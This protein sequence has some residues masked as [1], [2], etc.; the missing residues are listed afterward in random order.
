MDLRKILLLFTLAV[1]ATAQAAIV[2]EVEAVETVTSNIS[3]PTSTNGRLM[4][5]PCAESCDEKFIAVR[6]TTDTQF[7][8]KEQRVDFLEFRKQFFNMRRADEDYALV[9]FDTDTKTVTSIY[10]GL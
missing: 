6:L 10:I 9:S 2:T 1:S 3:V 7:F 4:F 5:R 8:V